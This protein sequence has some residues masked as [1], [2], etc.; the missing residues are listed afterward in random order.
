MEVY[1]EEQKPN[2]EPHNLILKAKKSILNYIGIILM[3]VTLLIIFVIASLETTKEIKASSGLSGKLLTEWRLANVKEDKMFPKEMT[4]IVTLGEKDFYFIIDTID[5]NSGEIIEWHFA[6]E[7]EHEETIKEKDEN[8][9]KSQDLLSKWQEENDKLITDLPSTEDVIIEDIEY[10][11]IVDETEVTIVEEIEIVTIIKWHFR[12]FEIIPAYLEEKIAT[13]AENG[14]LITEW[15]IVTNEL[16]NVYPEE[17]TDIVKYEFQGKEKDF[18]FVVDKYNNEGK[19]LKWHF[20]YDG[21]FAYIFGDYKFWVLT[22]ITIVMAMF[23]SYI[24]YVS[25]IQKAMKEEWFK[26]TLGYYK[27]KK[28]KVENYTQYIPDFCS[29]KNK[30]LYEMKK[31]EIIES[32]D[33]NYKWY[34]ENHEKGV[35][36]EPW[37][38][39][40]LQEIKKIK[41]DKMHASDLL[42]ENKKVGKKAGYLPIGQAEHQKRF[43]FSGLFTKTLTAFLGGFVIAFGVVISEWTAGLSYGITIIT[44]YAAAIMIANEFAENTLRNRFIAKGDLLGEFD[45]MKDKFIQKEESIIEKERE[46]NENERL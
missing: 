16:E 5:E 4:D 2:L 42:Q 41:I 8:I 38:H 31:K 6:Y 30:Q 3:V 34:L 10:K 35:K 45:N 19:I 46:E 7:I 32:A 44:S 24:N 20:A 40:K 11:F 23:V 43:L 1:K 28:D 29:Y 37:Q 27:S 12:S 15:R 14:K 9:V 26:N 18:Y 17:K 13:K 36:I 33:I 39:K 21:N 25:T 22:A